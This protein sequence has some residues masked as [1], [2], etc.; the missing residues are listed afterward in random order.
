MTED[1]RLTALARLSILDTPPEPAF[2]DAVALVRILCDTPIALVSLVDRDRQWFKAA[3]GVETCQTARDTSVCSL[4]ITG[5]GLLEITDLAADPRT[6]DMTL[7]REAPALRFYAGAPLVTSDGAPLGSLCAIDTKPRPEGLSQPQRDGL[8]IL[9]RQVTKMIETRRATESEARAIRVA[10]DTQ[11]H[12]RH[13]IDSAIDSAIIS[14]DEAGRVTAW[15]RGAET[16]F[17][18]TEAEMIGASLGRIFTPEDR[19]EGH[20]LQEMAAARETGR[21]ADKRWHLRKDGSR[22]FAHGAVT[23]LIGE[24]QPGYVKSL[25]DITAEH[26][27][28]RALEMSREEL[29][30]ATNAAQL[31]RFDYRP[32]S[33]RLTWDDRC[34]VLFGVGPGKPVSYEG[35]FLAGLHPEDRE[36]AAA[37][38]MAALDPAGDHTFFSEYRTIGIEDGLERHI[39]ANGLAF[40]AGETPTRLIGTVQDVTDNRRAL[41]D[42]AQTEERLRLAARATNDA[43]WDWDLVQDTVVW[44]EAMTT[45]YGHVGDAI[46]PTGAWWIDHIH[47]DDRDRVA[48]NIHAVIDGTASDWS[49]TYRFLRADGTYAD[50]KDRGFVIRDETG[51]A[52]RMIGAMLDQTEVRSLLRQLETRAQGLAEEVKIRTVERDRLW[53]TTSD[54]MG[55]AGQDGYL[56]EVNP[57]WQRLLG[58]T[59]AELLAR[60]FHDFIVPADHAPTTEAMTRLAR[61]EVVSNFTNRLHASDGG[62]RIISWD[63]V[64]E[65]DMFHIVG[66]DLTEQ[67][68]IEERLRQSQKMEAVGQLTGGIAHDFNNMLT[69]VIGSLDMMRRDIASERYDRVDRYMDA[70]TTSAQRAAGLTQRLLAFSR[71]QSLDVRS[72]DVGQLVTGMEELLRRTLGESAGLEVRLHADPWPARTDAN[73][74]ES[75][76]LNL[77]INA[78]DAMPDGGLLTIEAIN[79]TLDGLAATALA[80]DLAAGD[81][82]VVSVSD[83]GAGMSPTVIAKAFDPFFTTKPIGQGTGLGLSMIY[84]FTK[85][86][87][88]H[89]R[90]YSEEGHGTTVRLYLPRADAEAA[91]ASRAVTPLAQ[92]EAGECVL[93][94]EDD[95]AVRMLVVDV[96]QTLGYAVREAADGRAALPLIETMPRIDLL[97]TDVGLPGLNGRQ[98]AEIARDRLPG[99]PILFITGYAE[100]AAVRGGF[101]DEGMEM[102]TKPFAIDALSTRIRE[103]I[104]R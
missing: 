44:N 54:L 13:V 16:L 97:V 66:R 103:M 30:L 84:G 49:D 75:A 104:E 81:Y 47:L 69:G 45:A 32:G 29:E 72:V 10:D 22:F 58:R 19:A 73:Q 1:D 37:A 28:R 12:Y 57:A 40:F 35:T 96:L 102:I 59:E 5:D 14:I 36:A 61:G 100:K 56:K 27:N 15:S 4:A 52:T 87:G 46:D 91:G 17:G 11:R 24:G 21:V 64:P 42:L 18:W 41:L 89:V 26:E 8:A 65:G 43:I 9:G 7:V 95:P 20:P 76:L 2:D 90:I 6:C 88:G 51:R 83:T 70:A 99:L 62:Y 94:V 71:R 74:L 53:E 25:R 55:S 68:A 50:I 60:P 80:D 86:S 48:A 33:D 93:L 78:R 85:Q 82:V 101:L 63:A 3:S 92:A 23:P 38:V 77:A 67:H 98:V 39:L 31:G 79:Q 34:R